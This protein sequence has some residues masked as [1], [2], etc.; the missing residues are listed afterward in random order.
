MLSGDT[1][2]EG[3]GWSEVPSME[4]GAALVIGHDLDARV[5]VR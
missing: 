1:L 3:R 4:R 5:D 2:P